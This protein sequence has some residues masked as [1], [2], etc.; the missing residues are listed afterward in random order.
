MKRRLRHR[1]EA[2]DADINVTAFMNLMVVLVPFLLVM[3]VFSRLSILEIELPGG[4]AAA[5][6]AK[7]SLNLEIIVRDNSVLVVDRVSGSSQEFGKSESGY[8]L[9]ALANYLQ[10]LKAQHPEVTDA[11][12]LL[13]PDIAYENLIAVMD[14]VRALPVERQGEWEAVELFPEIAVGEAPE[15][16]ARSS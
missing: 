8:E 3:A 1:R 9:G 14:T 11:T 12:I 16:G 7:P 5:S 15:A 4:E 13:E 10:E 6:D 2:V